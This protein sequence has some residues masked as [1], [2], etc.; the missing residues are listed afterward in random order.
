[1]LKSELATQILELKLSLLEL[2]KTKVSFSSERSIADFQSFTSSS[3]M[4]ETGVSEDEADSKSK[5]TSE[6]T[7]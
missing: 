4:W 1:M 5:D 6:I 2:F 3:K 7:L